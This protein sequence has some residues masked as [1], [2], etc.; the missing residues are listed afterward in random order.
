MKMFFLRIFASTLV[1]AHSLAAQA[2]PASSVLSSRQQEE[3][4]E[5]SKSL[6][7][8]DV[9]KD[10]LDRLQHELGLK[11]DA[12]KNRNGMDDELKREKEE[13]EKLKS[14]SPPDE[15][16]IANLESSIADKEA[17]IRDGAAPQRLQGDIAA[18]EEEIKR[19]S[20]EITVLLGTL[21]G[22]FSGEQSFRV[23]NSITFAILIAIVILGFFFLAYIDSGVRTAIF[24]GESGI[25]FVTLFS[26]IIAIILF[27]ISGILEG[28]ELAALLGGLSGYILGRNT[29]TRSAAPPPDRGPGRPAPTAPG[30]RTK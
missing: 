13:L 2:N 29:S 4:R 16:K 19:K 27:G 18:L 17:A 10:D 3:A 25:Q 7:R 8:R 22:Q 14:A 9:L 12:L 28:K 20:A 6:I 26:L 24:S 11:K 23:W 15:V 1:V 5:I 30:R 21:S